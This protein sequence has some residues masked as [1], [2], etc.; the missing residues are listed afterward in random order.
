MVDVT[1]DCTVNVIFTSLV[2]EIP[3]MISVSVNV[4]S[5]GTI[6]NIVTES[7]NVADVFDCCVVRELITVAV[8]PDVPPVNLSPLR[9]V[10]VGEVRVIVGAAASSLVDSE[11]NTA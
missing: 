5:I 8:A 7:L 6:S 1:K 9:N 2:D 11:S 3:V 4:P 10:P